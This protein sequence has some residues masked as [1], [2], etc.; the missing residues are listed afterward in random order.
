MRGLIKFHR[1]FNAR[2]LH[3]DIALLVL[4][5][6]IQIGKFVNPV[7]LPSSE[8]YKKVL[9]QLRFFDPSLDLTY[10]NRTIPN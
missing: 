2:T 8:V 5:D 9:V 4:K 6:K 3:N 10:P 7:C 1:G